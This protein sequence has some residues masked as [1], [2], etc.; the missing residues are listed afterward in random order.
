MS[1]APGEPLRV[2]AVWTHPVQYLSPW[3]RWI[4]ASS[5]EIE[6]TV[7]YVVEPSADQQAVGFDTPFA[8]DVPLRDGYENRV[9][10]RADTG[11]AI[12]SQRFFGLDVPGMGAAIRQTRPDV[13]MLPGWYS[14]ALVR[15]LW[16]CKRAKIPVL[17]RG[18]STRASRSAGWRGALGAFRARLFAR[19]FDAALS[20]G[21][22]SDEYLLRHGVHPRRI[23]RAPHCVDVDRFRGAAREARGDR[24]ALRRGFSIPED[25]FVVLFAG[26]LEDIKRPLDAVR[27]VARLG[28]G[29][30]LAIAGTGPRLDD[31]RAEARR[32]GTAVVPLGFRNQ[33][34]MPRVYAAA[35]CLVLPS[36]SETWGLVV[37]EALACGVPCVVSDTV[38]CAPDLID[39]ATG[40][41]FRRGDVPALAAALARIRRKGPQVMRAACEERAHQG[42]FAHATAGL[43]RAARVAT[44]RERPRTRGARIL[45]LCGG[46]VQIY[47][48][49]R[50]TLAVLGVAR[51][52]GAAVHC[53]LNSWENHRVVP[54]IEALGG[55]WSTG[56][57]LAPLNKRLWRPDLLVSQGIDLL[58]NSHAVWQA[59]RRFRPTHIMAP[60]MGAVL[61]HAPALQLMRAQGVRVILRAG[62]VPERS[63]LHERVWRRGVAP[64]VDRIVA[65]SRFGRQRLIESGI[66]PSKVDLI[67]NAVPSSD[68]S[69]RHDDLTEFLDHERVLLCVGQIAPFKG[70]H[71]AV[72][73][74]LDLL[75][76]GADVRLLIVGHLPTWPAAYVRYAEAL[77]REIEDRDAGGRIRF[78]GHRTDVL[79]LMQRSWLLLAPIL[80]E[81]TFGNVVLEAKWSGLPVVATRRGGLPELVEHEQ[82]GYLCRAEDAGAV[83]SGVQ[84][85]LD[86]TTRRADA[87]DA[88]R[89][90]FESP[91]GRAYLPN[92]FDRAWLGQFSR[93]ASDPS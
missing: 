28:S 29:A 3:F 19:A 86:D 11:D 81:E 70:T 43:I 1:D 20:V 32:L 73:A 13:V 54:R 74:T 53:I 16:A 6:L 37:N 64:F 10:R 83:R 69:S 41:V 25:A 5:P 60:E 17:Y 49:E 23:V 4:A 8:W 90:F 18:D 80:Q 52:G 12:G 33:S 45:A 44:G 66:R 59:G 46:F 71:V 92:A 22:R 62:N 26:K 47:G 91:E 38:G 72:R 79:S 50:L 21:R 51:R 40:A 15:A 2:T 36:Q 67:H 87:S 9:L 27:A 89:V 93:T 7:L 58:A 63:A 31:V 56:R 85:F 77:Q 24:L 61:R 57:Y 84:W 34:E 88:S 68:A 39:D 82:T 48:L 76:D 55:T 75:A 78:A 14:V 42:T 65:N 30:V 35:D